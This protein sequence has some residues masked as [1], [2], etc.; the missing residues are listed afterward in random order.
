MFKIN[1]EY[2]YINRHSGPYNNYMCCME[3]EP[4]IHPTQDLNLQPPD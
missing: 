1:T 4:H 3:T 2:T